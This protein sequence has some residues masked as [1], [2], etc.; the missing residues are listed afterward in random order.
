VVLF[1]HMMRLEVRTA[2]TR[3]LSS[4]PYILD[5]CVYS[6]RDAEAFVIRLG[7]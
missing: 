6:D 2:L 3:P 1:E 5:L 7:G 4:L